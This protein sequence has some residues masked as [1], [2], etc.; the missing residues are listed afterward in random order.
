MNI[1]LISIIIFTI[2][3]IGCSYKQPL[4]TSSA[5]IIFKTPQIKFYDKGFITKYTNHIHLQIFQ[6]GN[7]VL[8]LKIYK[9]TICQSTLKCM[10]SK[11]FNKKYL[12]K[13]YEDDF[14][15][16]T[17]SKENISYKDTINKILIKV[18]K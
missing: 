16:R 10:S 1:K 9:N 13:S 8:D 14:L 12:H 5:I 15:Y 11:E 6:V 4:Y 7:L 3:L 2:L 17:F 18:K